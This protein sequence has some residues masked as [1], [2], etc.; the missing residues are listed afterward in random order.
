MAKKGSDDIIDLIIAL[1]DMIGMVAKNMKKILAIIRKKSKGI[2][3]PIIKTETIT[4]DGN[5]PDLN[6]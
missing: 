3:K 4:T 2:K 5:Q 6:S 1:A